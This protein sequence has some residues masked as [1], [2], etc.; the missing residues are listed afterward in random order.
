LPNK[1]SIDG[2]LR[3][4]SSAGKPGK[5]GSGGVRTHFTATRWLLAL[6]I[7]VG[8]QLLG[9]VLDV[10]WHAAHGSHFRS[11]SE[12][13]QAHWVIWV[14]I[15]VTMLSAA[16]AVRAGHGRASRGFL[17]ALVTSVVFAA[18]SGWNFWEHAHGRHAIAPHVLMIVS[19]IGV[20]V[21]AVWVT[22]DLLGWQDPQVVGSFQG[23]R[24]KPKA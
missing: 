19:R 4:Q 3:M 12:Q 9:Q 20:V 11:A 24:T 16:A 18:A 10:R 21:A 15:A 5:A 22:H 17:W 8:I 7:G 14:S 2:N 6:W 13:V 23:V 1:Q